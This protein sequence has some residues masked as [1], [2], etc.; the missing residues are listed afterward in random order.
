MRV[1]FGRQPSIVC[2]RPAA[3]RGITRARARTGNDLRRYPGLSR[4][5]LVLANETPEGHF[6]GSGNRTHQYGR[7]QWRIPWAQHHWFR[8]TTR[9]G[10]CPLCLGGLDL[11]GQPRVPCSAAPSY[12]Q[13]GPVDTHGDDMTICA[14]I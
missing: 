3:S 4:G 11:R 6:R 5:V 9:R 12:I 13:A 14:K 2:D 8:K 1:H 7:R 10:R